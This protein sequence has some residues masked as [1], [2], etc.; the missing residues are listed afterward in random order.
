MYIFTLRAISSTEMSACSSSLPCVSTWLSKSD[1]TIISVIYIYI[2]NLA[3]WKSLNMMGF[4]TPE[5]PKLFIK[6][7]GKG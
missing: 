1:T 4:S 5:I 6:I 7:H 3:Y 2:S